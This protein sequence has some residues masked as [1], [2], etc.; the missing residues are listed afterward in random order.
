M[1]NKFMDSKLGKWTKRIVVILIVLGL[2]AFGVVKL[3]QNKTSNVEKSALETLEALDSYYME[4]SMDFYK[5]EDTRS[6]TVKIS[7]K[8]NADADLFK[9]SMYDKAVNQEQIIIKNKDGVYV[10]TPALNQAY[11]FNGEW[12]LNGH[13]PYLYQSM[14]ETMQG[15]CDI[16]KLD[17]GYLVTPT[18]EFKNMPS[19]ARQ[20]MKLSKE[21]K[22]LWV[23]IYDNNNDVAVKIG[24]NKVEFNPTFSENYFNVEDNVK[25]SREN[26]STTTSSTIDDLPL[27]PTN[28]D[29]DA[30]LKEVSNITVNGET[31]VM[32]TYEGKEN[33]TVIETSV[34]SFE[35][36]TEIEVSGEIVN[37]FG[38]YGYVVSNSNINKLYFTYNGVSYQ[39]W[40]NCVDVA[41]LIE[42]ASGMEYVEE[43]K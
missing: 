43:V 5:G 18:P 28:A 1:K 26:I 9:V 24:F 31:Q 33:F 21:Y 40:S 41:T 17:D 11:K 22:P 4:A 20:E 30:S 13:K 36:Y 29:V 19:W 7:Y 35:Q 8:D 15:D 25:E 32:L 42:V 6:Y 37:I 10:L 38:V 14:V 39:L 12:P 16:S 27:Y 2:V 34:E 3:I 23:H